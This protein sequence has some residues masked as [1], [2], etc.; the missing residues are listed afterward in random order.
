MDHDVHGGQKQQL[1]QR[2]SESWQLDLLASEEKSLSETLCHRLS[3]GLEKNRFPPK[4]SPKQLLNCNIAGKKRHRFRFNKMPAVFW[5]NICGAPTQKHVGGLRRR[6]FRCVARPAGGE[7]RKNNSDD[8][9]ASGFRKRFF[10]Y[11]IRR[12]SSKK[13]FC[14]ARKKSLHF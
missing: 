6:A 10:L 5:T 3:H 11:I 7:E 12:A 1:A 13:L 8:V 4:T 2:R 9:L 14:H